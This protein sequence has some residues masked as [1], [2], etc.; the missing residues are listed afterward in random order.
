[1]KG[2]SEVAV[3]QLEWARRYKAVVSMNAQL[4][5]LMMMHAKLRTVVPYKYIYIQFSEHRT[6]SVCLGRSLRNSL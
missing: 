1:M 2:I 6:T 4:K 5:F 3:D